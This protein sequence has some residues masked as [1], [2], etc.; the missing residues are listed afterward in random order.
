MGILT[1]R[2]CGAKAEA[3]TIKEADSLID[4]ARGKAIGRPCAGELSYLLWD[5]KQAYRKEYVLLV[6]DSTP[7]QAKAKAAPKPKPAQSTPPPPPPPPKPQ[8]PA[9]TK[10]EEDSSTKNAL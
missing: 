5:G 9:A 10:Q 6:K 3:D 7:K 4:H 2:Y 8:Q 1:C